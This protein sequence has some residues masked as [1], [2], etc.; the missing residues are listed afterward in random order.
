MNLKVYLTSTNVTV[1]QGLVEVGVAPVNTV[2][3]S[4]AIVAAEEI[5]VEVASVSAAIAATDVLI[6]FII[7]VCNGA[8]LGVISHH[9]IPIPFKV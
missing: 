5:P 4:Y 2:S 8:T 9:S 1:S 6:N 3:T 7:I